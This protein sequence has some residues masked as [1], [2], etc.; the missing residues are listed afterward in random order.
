MG[1]IKNGWETIVHCMLSHLEDWFRSD[2]KCSLI[3][4]P[5]VQKNSYIDFGGNFVAGLLTG[6]QDK[7]L[8][9]K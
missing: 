7:L 1:L 5:F 4:L 9:A 3:C 8:E 2:L 6:F